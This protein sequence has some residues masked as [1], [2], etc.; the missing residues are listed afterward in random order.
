MDGGRVIVEDEL[1]TD[2][3]AG[4]SDTG[5]IEDITDVD[6]RESPEP[7][8][9]TSAL[10]DWSQPRSPGQLIG[11]SSATQEG[12]NYSFSLYRKENGKYIFVLEVSNPSSS[13]INLSFETN[14][15]FD[16][17]ISDLVNLRWNYNN[18]RF[19]V[20]SQQSDTI[21]P[22]SSGKLE[23]RSQEWDATDNAGTALPPGS[24]RFEAV[25]L[26]SGNPVQ[27]SFEA[28]LN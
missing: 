12:L 26:L 11:S 22:G 24:Y 8:T 20:Q 15:R 16:F 23:Y 17:R 6:E 3:G 10:P 7:D 25:Y 1:L 2:T 9:S 28:T 19:F 5:F 14:E 18:N 4:R 13:P 27:L 21:E